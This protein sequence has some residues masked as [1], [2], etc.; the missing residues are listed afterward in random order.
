M[1]N[2]FATAQAYKN[3]IAA[4]PGTTSI[5]AHSLGNLVV[6]SAIQDKGLTAFA[7]YFAIDAA[8]A[9]EAYGQVADVAS[10]VNPDGTFA[11]DL[12]ADMIK[13]EDW[14]DYIAAGQSRLLASEWYKLFQD[15]PLVKPPTDNRS[16]LTWRNRLDKV[17]SDDVGTKVYNFYSSTEDVLR[18]YADDDLLWDGAGA[19]PRMYSWVKQEKFKGR[20]DRIGNIPQVGADV[21]GSSSNYGG[22]SFNSGYSKWSPL[23]LNQK[24][25]Y[26]PEE[27]ALEIGGTALKPVPFFALDV[28]HLFSD[29]DS[30]LEP[31][32]DNLVESVG[33]V[34]PS[35]FVLKK[36]SETGLKGYYANNA[37][38]HGRVLVRDWLLAEAFPATTLP[39]GGNENGKLI[40]EGHNLNMAIL[41]KTNE[42]LW[43]RGSSFVPSVRDWWHSDFKDVPYQHTCEFYKRV[44][45]IIGN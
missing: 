15:D 37:S 4:V 26:T 17:V 44:E 18:R 5:A 24:R 34:T 31:S 39:M 14:P 36:V 19:N 33:G 40:I 2:A 23:S 22:W 16:Q 12:S 3:F 20:R 1:V 42:A 43:P 13:V 30:I 7:K 11:T 27:A 10:L 45:F 35:D 21:G 8:V 9:L 41:F 32:L 29:P 6:G 38:A 25:H 28:W